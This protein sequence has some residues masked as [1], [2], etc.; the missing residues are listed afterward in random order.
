MLWKHKGEQRN[1]KK[2]ISEAYII[3]SFIG[4]CKEFKYSKFNEKLL[5]SVHLESDII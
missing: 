5:K 4:H 2:M 3:P 1:A